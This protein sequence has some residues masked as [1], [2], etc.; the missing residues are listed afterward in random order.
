[1]STKIEESREG[2]VAGGDVGWWPVE[3]FD[4]KFDKR[5]VKDNRWMS[6]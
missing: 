3:C 4:K 6:R 1:M 2:F 5:Q